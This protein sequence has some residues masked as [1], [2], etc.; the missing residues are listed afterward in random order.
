M[1][2]YGE[3]LISLALLQYTSASTLPALPALHNSNELVESS[4]PDLQHPVSQ[5][6]SLAVLPYTA[7]DEQHSQLY[8]PLP[9][10]ALSTDD[11][12]FLPFDAVLSDNV[13][14]AENDDSILDDKGY[15]VNQRYAMNDFEQ[16]NNEENVISEQGIIPES[17]T[18]GDSKIPHSKR[19]KANKQTSAPLSKIALQEKSN[20]YLTGNHDASMTHD[21]SG[22]IIFKKFML[23]F[24]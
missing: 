18:S 10:S 8:E 17:Q 21:I 5:R 6:S 2:S 24:S 23:T 4:L 14:I 1:L 19:T 9:Y 22:K 7:V 15:D 20:K 13:A 12:N 11:A 16:N 3:I